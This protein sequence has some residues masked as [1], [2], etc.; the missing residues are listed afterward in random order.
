[1]SR[2]SGGI[3]N[4][5]CRITHMQQ[6]WLHI[7]RGFALTVRLTICTSC[8]RAAS[9]GRPPGARLLEAL[10]A[11][12]GRR[13]AGA[14]IVG[15]ECLWACSQ[16]CTIL[17]QAEGKTGYVAGGFEPDEAAAAAILDWCDAYGES[18]DGRVAYRQWPEGMKGRF[19][20]RI[21]EGQQ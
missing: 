12:R 10:K 20:A 17:I 1:M 4:G 11:E 7:R 9:S 6:A 8:G 5:A 18:A 2:D 15:H 14:K 16:S 19:I 3:G 21:P 13:P